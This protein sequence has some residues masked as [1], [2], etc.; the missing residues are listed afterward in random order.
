[1][2]ELLIVERFVDASSVCKALVLVIPTIRYDRPNTFT[3]RRRQDTCDYIGEYTCCLGITP[4][5]FI[6]PFSYFSFSKYPQLLFDTFPL[7][8]LL[9]LP[10][11]C[12][13]LFSFVRSNNEKKGD[14]AKFTPQWLNEKITKKHKSAD[15]TTLHYQD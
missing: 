14:K 4:S 13:V 11:I 1:M 8:L 5:R 2:W 7:L 3:G 15:E 6:S 10:S 12:F 9:L